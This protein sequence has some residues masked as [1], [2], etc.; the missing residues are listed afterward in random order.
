MMRHIVLLTL[1]AA[2]LIT[3]LTVLAQPVGT[4]MP[5]TE[6]QRE[7]LLFLYEDASQPVDDG[8]GV[9]GEKER[10]RF[11]AEADPLSHEIQ[12]T[13]HRGGEFV[14][15]TDSPVDAAGCLFTF[16]LSFPVT[17]EYSFRVGSTPLAIIPFDVIVNSDAPL[18]LAMDQYGSRTPQGEGIAV[19]TPLPPSTPDPETEF[20]IVARIEGVESAQEAVFANQNSDDFLTEPWNLFVNTYTLDSSGSASESFPTVCDHIARQMDNLHDVTAS[21]EISVGRLGDETCAF[22]DGEDGNNVW[23]ATRVGSHILTV[24]SVSTGGDTV[25]FT[26]DWLDEYLKS[27]PDDIESLM[28]SVADMPRG[29]SQ[30]RDIDDVTDE[31]V[32]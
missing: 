22:I 31:T 4:A 32:P 29:W 23:V 11:F 9:S 12:W 16:D 20:R 10:A 21:R 26:A 25:D 2:L 7:V 30:L 3:P 27:L 1:L 13:I 24:F 15:A 18:I 28:P 19:P 5:T 14:T 8:C 6:A 17:R